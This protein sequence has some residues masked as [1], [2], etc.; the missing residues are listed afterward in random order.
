MNVFAKFHGVIAEV[1]STAFARELESIG[2]TH[3]VTENCNIKIGLV[4]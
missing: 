2:D 1:I 4:N 3:S